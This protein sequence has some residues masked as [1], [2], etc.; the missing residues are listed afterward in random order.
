MTMK[1]SMSTTDVDNSGSDE[2]DGVNVNGSDER[3][4]TYDSS[5]KRDIVNTYD[6]GEKGVRVNIDGGSDR[7]GSAV[8]TMRRESQC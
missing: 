8:L 2:R 1:E 7:K 6:G 3:V 4:D 5:D